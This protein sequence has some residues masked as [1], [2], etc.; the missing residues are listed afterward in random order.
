MYPVHFSRLF[1][2]KCFSVLS[3]SGIKSGLR[4]SVEGV[5]AA[6][7]QMSACARDMLYI[8]VCCRRL[9]F[10]AS[11]VRKNMGI[12]IHMANILSSFSCKTTM[13]DTC[14]SAI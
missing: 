2:E 10:G 12:H 9:I 13:Q 6:S 14:T 1:T 3:L 5:M 8:Y 11:N 7:T 4:S